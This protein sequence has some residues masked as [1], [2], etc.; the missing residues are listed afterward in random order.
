MEDHDKNVDRYI[1]ILNIVSGSENLALSQVE[2]GGGGY[3]LSS[4]LAYSAQSHHAH[5]LATRISPLD[6]R[7]LH[8][9]LD[10]FRAFWLDDE[11]PYVVALAVYPAI[12]IVLGCVG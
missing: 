3:S 4:R 10:L 1:P 8:T 6:H 12:M 2:S 11:C 7:L 5:M 9:L